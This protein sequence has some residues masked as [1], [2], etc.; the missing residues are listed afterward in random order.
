MQTT[1]GLAASSWLCCHGTPTEGGLGHISAAWYNC[2]QTPSDGPAHISKVQTE[3]FVLYPLRGKG[4][5]PSGAPGRRRSLETPTLPS[6]NRT[7]KVRCTSQ[8]E[9]PLEPRVITEHAQSPAC[10]IVE[11]LPQRPPQQ[12]QLGALSGTFG[13]LS[14]DVRQV[15]LPIKNSEQHVSLLTESNCY[16]T[17][18]CFSG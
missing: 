10:T 12:S 1:P 8:L 17:M 2:H 7:V 16:S 13:S 14:R 9:R 3:S 15:S 4:L 6:S 5:R 11:G 18:V